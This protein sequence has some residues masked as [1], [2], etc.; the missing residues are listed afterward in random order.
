MAR[1][2]MTECDNLI[3]GTDNGAYARHVQGH[4]LGRY[5]PEYHEKVLESSFG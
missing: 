1:G 5:W 4:C 3:R 2:G